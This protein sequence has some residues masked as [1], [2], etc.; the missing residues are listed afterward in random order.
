MNLVPAVAGALCNPLIH[1]A[2]R[3][4][5]MTVIVLALART[6]SGV[7]EASNIYRRSGMRAKRGSSV[8]EVSCLPLAPFQGTL[9][10]EPPGRREGLAPATNLSASNWITTSSSGGFWA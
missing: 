4:E 5:I 2:T 7:T 8:E 1:S 3:S 6:P 10:D 9:A